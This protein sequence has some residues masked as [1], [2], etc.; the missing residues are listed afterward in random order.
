MH[1]VHCND[2]NVLIYINWY[3]FWASLAHHQ[4]VQCCIQQSLDLIIIS[5]MFGLSEVHHCMIYRDGYV[6]GNWSSLQVWVCSQTAPITVHKPISINHTVMNWQF[7]ILEMIIRSNMFHLQVT[8]I[9]QT[10][11]YTGMTCSVL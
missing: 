5:N 2:N 7:Q 8:I 10:F 9:R 3:I 6:H 1:T 4:W 11:Q